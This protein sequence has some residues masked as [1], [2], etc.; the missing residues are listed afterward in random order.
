MFVACDQL[1]VVLQRECGDPEIIVGN[2]GA[3]ALK[4]N[5]QTVIVLSRLPIREQNPNRLAR[6]ASP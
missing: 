6:V 2:R 1:Q 3:G 5:E 4:L